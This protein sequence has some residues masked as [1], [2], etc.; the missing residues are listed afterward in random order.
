MEERQKEKAGLG[1]VQKNL[2]DVIGDD[3]SYHGLDARCKGVH[4]HR[5][6]CV[7]LFF[8]KC[9][10]FLREREQFRPQESIE[11]ALSEFLRP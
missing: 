6:R 4:V 10:N 2:N 8:G 9:G 5:C 7:P 3:K 1:C 11:E